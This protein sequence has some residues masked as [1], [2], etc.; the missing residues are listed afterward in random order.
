MGSIEWLI[1]NYYIIK[2]TWLAVPVEQAGGLPSVDSNR[3]RN[4]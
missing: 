1:M 4:L 2:R 3:N